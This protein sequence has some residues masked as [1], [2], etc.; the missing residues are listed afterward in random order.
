ML[1][2]LK[3]YFKKGRVKVELAVGH[4]KTIAD[5]RETLKRKTANREVD[6]AIR[7]AQKRRG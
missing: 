1:V 7:S 2:P 6:Q 5:K 3:L 4:G